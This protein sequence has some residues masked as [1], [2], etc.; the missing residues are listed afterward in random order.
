[1]RKIDIL[2]HLNNLKIS[3]KITPTLVIELLGI[4]IVVIATIIEMA[5]IATTGWLS[6]Y[7]YNGDSLTLPLLRQSLAHKET[8]LWASSS[9]LNLFPEFVIYAISSAF[10]HSVRASLFLNSIFNVLIFYFLARVLLNQVSKASRYA[11]ELL[12]LIIVL[13]LISYMLLES[14][15]TAIQTL[16]T[17]YLF[18]TYYY[19]VIVIG[20]AQLIITLHQIKANYSFKDKKYISLSV[21]GIILSSLAAT[22][23]PLYFTQMLLPIVAALLIFWLLKYINYRKFLIG[24]IPLLIS[25]V[26]GLI[27]RTFVKSLIARSV[28]SYFGHILSLVN[29]KYNLRLLHEEIT[30]VNVNNLRLRIFFSILVFSVSLFFA[31]FA[32]NDKIKRRKKIEKIMS[33]KVFISLFV[34]L[35]FFSASLSALVIE[36]FEGRYLVAPLIIPVIGLVVLIDTK[37]FG[38]FRRNWLTFLVIV[39]LVILPLGISDISKAN[40]LLASTAPDEQCLEAA[41]DYKPADG[42]ADYWIAR[43]LDVYNTYNQRVLQL[44]PQLLI[45]P[46]QNNLASYQNK[47]FT[48]IVFPTVTLTGQNI[49]PQNYLQFGKPSKVSDCKDIYVYQYL[50]KTKGYYELNNRLDASLNLA[51]KLR[52]LGNLG[53]YYE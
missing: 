9:Q 45:M 22:S 24:F 44:D 33:L 14:P 27:G 48:F 42:V 18:T 2:K 23:N 41:L 30:V 20:L 36:G 16:A 7:L 53:A 39:S 11:K 52:K 26:L 38:F 50:P 17:Y 6:L 34:V 13:V 28:S 19:G 29:F 1:M 43:Y 10:A 40:A 31:L 21:F 32:I 15:S 51:L 47:K 46:W 5:H 37:F 49:N 4:A 25:F 8:F 35:E 12:A 3:K